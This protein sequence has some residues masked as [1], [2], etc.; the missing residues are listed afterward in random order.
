MRPRRGRQRERCNGRRRGRRRRAV[1][2]E[3]A[4]PRACSERHGRRARRASAPTTSAIDRERRR[5]RRRRTSS[6]PRSSAPACR[7]SRPGP[8][9]DRAVGVRLP[10]AERVRLARVGAPEE[11]EAGGLAGRHLA[12]V[13]RHLRD[14][15]VLARAGLLRRRASSPAPAMNESIEKPSGGVSSTFVVVAFSFSVGTASVNTW[16]SPFERRSAG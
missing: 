8:V 11:R 16:L 5:R 14:H 7:S 12:A 3:R 1:S 15:R 9:D 13:P 4:P 6:S 10:D 2:R